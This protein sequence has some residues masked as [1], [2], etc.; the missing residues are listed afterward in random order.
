MRGQ[1]TERGRLVI[2]GD[3]AA[4]APDAHSA[5]V[6]AAR[7]WQVVLSAGYVFGCAYRSVVPVH[8]VLRICLFDSWL[9]SIVVGRLV[10]TVA[11]LCFVAPWAL[12]LRE[13][14]RATGSGVGT[15]VSKVVPPL[16]LIAEACSWY[17][18]LTT[19]NFGHVVEESI[20]GLRG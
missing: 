11:E 17:S 12:M 6:Y 5:E 9:S 8:D 2:V 15:A 7:R 10:A 1:R 13:V 19:S 4:A 16:I 3:V 14:S 18:V 20:W